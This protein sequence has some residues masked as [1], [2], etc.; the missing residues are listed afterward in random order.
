M[1]VTI[2]MILRWG[3]DDPWKELFFSPKYKIEERREADGHVSMKTAYLV[4]EG[5]PMEPIYEEL[6][7]RGEKKPY[8]RKYIPEEIERNRR[9]TSVIPV[10]QR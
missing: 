1:V 6:F 8:S 7:H 2:G 3:V 5:L 4:R 10:F 9:C